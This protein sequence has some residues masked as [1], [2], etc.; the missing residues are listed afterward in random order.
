MPAV[1]GKPWTAG[2]W[3]TITGDGRSVNGGVPQ[4]ASLAAH[5]AAL[6]ATVVTWI[7]DA[8]WTGNAV[9][10]FEAWSA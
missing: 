10:D 6:K 1:A 7:P 9:F 3:P 2:L 8:G 5:V 4:N